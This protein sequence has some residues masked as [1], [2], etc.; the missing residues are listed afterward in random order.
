LK[1][2]SDLPSFNTE[3][4]PIKQAHIRREKTKEDLKPFLTILGTNQRAIG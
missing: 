3:D 2:T 1:E 4:S